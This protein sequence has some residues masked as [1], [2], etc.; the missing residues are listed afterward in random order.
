MDGPLRNSLW[1]LLY[2]IVS[3]NDRSRTAWTAILRGACL[4]FFKET[5]DDLPTADNDASLREFKRL[6][7]GIPGHRV[8]DLFEFLLVDDRAGMKEMDRK[9][10]RRGLN[11]VLEEERAPV[12]LMRDRLVPLADEVSLDALAGAEES[13]S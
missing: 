11:P 2:R 10:L 4:A 1:N 3:A 13:L 7:S 5:I 9:L 12:R 8:Y 6:F